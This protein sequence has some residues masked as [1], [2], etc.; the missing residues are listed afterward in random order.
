VNS[1]IFISKELLSVYRVFKTSVVFPIKNNRSSFLKSVAYYG[2]FPF[3]QTPERGGGMS[4]CVLK[5]KVALVLM[6]LGVAG[7]FLL[8]G[9]ITSPTSS[10]SS[11]SPIVG[12]WSFSSGADVCTG[13]IYHNST[14]SGS[15]QADTTFNANDLSGMSLN[16]ANGGTVV[17]TIPFFSSS[18]TLNGTWSYSSEDSNLTMK[19]SGTS[20]WPGD[21][22]GKFSVTGSTATITYAVI[23]DTL[24]SGVSTSG[25]RSDTTS[26]VFVGSEVVKMSKE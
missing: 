24:S 1:A 26:N 6:I 9:C 25:T 8:Q 16:F 10:T 21:R 15:K 12:T 3:H 7:I 17:A 2:Y 11:S 20:V 19:I 22:T 5:S 23:A 13:T 14:A 4:R 18:L